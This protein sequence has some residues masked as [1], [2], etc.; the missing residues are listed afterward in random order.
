MKFKLL[1]NNG[2]KTF[3]L[4]LNDGDNVTECITSFAQEQHLHAAQ[5]TAIGAFSEA[6]LG[7]FDFSIKDYK[8]IEIKQQTEVLTLIGD[9]SVYKNKPLLHAHVVL[10]KEDGTAY[11]GHLLHA[12]VHP[13]LEIIVTESPAWLM[14]KMNEAI[15]IP[16]IAVEQ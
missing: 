14:R 2:Q 10:G 4:I 3:A 6:T 7:F 15:G 12:I 13:T 5:I 16:L 8:K 9:I 11:G 1:N